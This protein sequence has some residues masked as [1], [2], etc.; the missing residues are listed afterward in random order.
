MMADSDVRTLPVRNP[1]TGAVDFQLPVA[2]AEEVAEKAARLRANQ[3]AW[4]ALPLAGRIGVMR[5]W[6]GEVARR[7]DEIAGADAA[8]TGGCHT[9]WLQGFITM[10]N[11]GGWI[12]DAEAALERVMYHGP[13]KAMPEVEVRT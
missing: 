12:E 11:I 10:G 5:R 9:S 2:S 7:A 3:P 4:A 1:R 6:L 8:D 13:S